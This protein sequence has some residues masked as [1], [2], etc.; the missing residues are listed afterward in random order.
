M[1]VEAHS[2]V[3][4][5]HAAANGATVDGPKTSAMINVSLTANTML[6]LLHATV[7]KR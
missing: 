2:S 5:R 1:N 4:S 7:V 3:L 6:L